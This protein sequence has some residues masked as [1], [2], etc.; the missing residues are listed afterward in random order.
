MGE[1]VLPSHI[2]KE[3]A[4]DKDNRKMLEIVDSSIVCLRR[5]RYTF[6]V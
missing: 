2:P 4:A 3:R 6:H 5:S 1:H